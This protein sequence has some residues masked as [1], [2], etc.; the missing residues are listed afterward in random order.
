MKLPGFQRRSLDEARRNPVSGRLRNCLGYNKPFQAIATLQDFAWGKG[1]A[2]DRRHIC[3]HAK[4][5]IEVR[6]I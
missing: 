3:F 1:Y 2:T 6:D 5:V 4:H